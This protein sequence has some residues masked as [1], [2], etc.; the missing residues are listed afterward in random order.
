MGQSCPD[1]NLLRHTAHAAGAAKIIGNRLTQRDVSL[2][3]PRQKIARHIQLIFSQRF[4]DGIREMDRV[5]GIRIKIETKGFLLFFCFL[6]L[7]AVVPGYGK[8]LYMGDGVYK[9]TSFFL[10]LYISLSYQLLVG[11]VHGTAA[12]LQIGGK[13][14][15][16]GQLFASQK[17]C[18]ENFPSDIFINLYIHGGGGLRIK[19][20]GYHRFLLAVYSYQYCSRTWVRCL[21]NTVFIFLRN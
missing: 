7:S 8:L 20:Y 14:S 15:G 11:S 13:T 4:P 12:D 6:A 16:G 3:V 2:V 10:C 17:A 18:I 19:W 5:N 21:E 9:K 1:N